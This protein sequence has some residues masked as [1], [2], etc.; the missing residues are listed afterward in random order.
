MKIEIEI[1]KKRNEAGGRI[2]NEKW[3]ARFLY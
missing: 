2:I 3:M 1:E